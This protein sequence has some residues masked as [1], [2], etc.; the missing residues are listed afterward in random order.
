M[1]GRDGHPAL[2]GVRRPPRRRRP[3]RP[4]H[5][6]ARVAGSA[7][8]RATAT[9]C[10]EDGVLVGTGRAPASRRP[11]DGPV[12]S[13]GAANGCGC[14]ARAR[15][16]SSPPARCRGTWRWRRRRP[17][18]ASASS[19]ATCSTVTATYDSKRASWYE[20]MGIMP[21]AFNPGGTGPDPFVDERRRARACSPTGTCTRTATTAASFSGLADPRQAARRR[22]RRRAARSRSTTSCTA[23]AT[24]CAPASAGARRRSAAGGTLK[25]VNRDASRGI[26]HSIT[27]CRAPCNRTTGIAYPLANGH[28]PV[29]LGQPRLRPGGRDG[30]GQPRDVEHAAQPARRHLHVLLQDPPVHARRRSASESSA[31]TRAEAGRSARR[32]RAARPRTC[33]LVAPRAARA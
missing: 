13:S 4:L 25:F 31:K 20:S 33:A 7:A 1:A 23:A 8:T 19:A 27:S 9:S 10:R 22:R 29:R 12:R 24:C 17:T 30:R 28:G 21:V 2:P 18:G 5:V 26:L 14:S 16:T 11:V 6:P 3:R 32:R 15:S